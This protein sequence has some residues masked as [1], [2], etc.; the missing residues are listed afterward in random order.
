MT[1]VDL[2]EKELL[3]FIGRCFEWRNADVLAFGRRD[4]ISRLGE[5]AGYILMMYRND[6]PRADSV[7]I[8]LPP[9]GGRDRQQMLDEVHEGVQ[10]AYRRFQE[11]D[12]K[13]APFVKKSI[14]KLEVQQTA[15]FTSASLAVLLS[16]TK[17]RQAVI[18]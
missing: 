9:A 11:D 16:A 14:A 4:S 18:V 3:S 6:K 8:V 7:R 15:D 13:T 17:S 5:I 2:N 1:V 10:R 12:A